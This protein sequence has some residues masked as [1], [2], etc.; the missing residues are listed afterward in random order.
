[1]S[2][3]ELIVTRDVIWRTRPV[4]QVVEIVALHDWTG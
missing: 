4:L 2:R 3:R 1:M